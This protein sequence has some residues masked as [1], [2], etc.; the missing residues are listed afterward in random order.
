MSKILREVQFMNKVIRGI[1]TSLLILGFIGLW[2][3]ETLSIQ[4]RKERS[5]DVLLDR[6]IG[7]N[8]HELF[9]KCG[10]PTEEWRA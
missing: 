4:E 5:E 2:G 1:S 3:C 9:A 7:V 10:Q 6:W 8:A